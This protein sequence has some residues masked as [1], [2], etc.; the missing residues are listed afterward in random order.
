MSASE[1]PI[2]EGFG[3]SGF[4]IVLPLPP[5]ANRLW[6]ASGRGAYPTP[7][8]KLWLEQAADHLQT[9]LP[10]GWEPSRGWWGVLGSVHLGAMTDASAHAGNGDGHN[11]IKAALDALQGMDV[12][13]QGGLVGEKHYKKGSIIQGPFG[14]YADDRTVQIDSWCV[15]EMNAPSAYLE[16]CFTP[17]Q[18]PP[19]RKA[20]A[21]ALK[22]AEQ[23]RIAAERAERKA[24]AE[25]EKQQK[26]EARER[27][28]LC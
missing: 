3:H 25:G 9:L 18:P 21:A 13:R 20:E 8:Y 6:R 11:Y 5:S 26:R 23:E 17:T 10:E 4:R 12:V 16:M 14:L 19:D 22:R 27:K 1:Q 24:A 2:T 7:E 28:R 15:V